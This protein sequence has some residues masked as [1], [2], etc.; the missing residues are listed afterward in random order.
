VCQRQIG[1]TRPHVM[2][3]L[4]HWTWDPNFSISQIE[5]PTYSIV[6]PFELGKEN[7]D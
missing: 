4:H 1:L 7:A 2:Q 6:Q 5:V 3:P